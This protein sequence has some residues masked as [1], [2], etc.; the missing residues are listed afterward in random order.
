MRAV[1]SDTYKSSAAEKSDKAAIKKLAT[2]L[3]VPESWLCL[4]ECGCWHITGPSGHIYTH[5]SSK[6]SLSGY[7]VVCHLGGDGKRWAHIKSI[8]GG[9]VRQDGDGEG[10]VLLSEN[11]ID[12]P[13]VRKAIGC[14]R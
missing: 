5:S 2:R 8:L 11:E 9:I 6:G 1:P 3:K 4:D 7:L 13:S 10:V 14:V 12:A